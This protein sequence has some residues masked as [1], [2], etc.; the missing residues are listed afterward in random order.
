MA[1]SSKPKG[2]PRV[3]KEGQGDLYRIGGVDIPYDPEL[4]LDKP[5]PTPLF[6]VSVA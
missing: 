6:P 2:G 1:P 4:E 5:K 3:K